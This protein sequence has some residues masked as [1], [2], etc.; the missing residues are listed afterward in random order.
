MF[1]IAAAGTVGQSLGSAPPEPSGRRQGAAS[2][3][4]PLPPAGPRDLPPMTPSTA[5]SRPWPPL[6]HGQVALGWRVV[7]A[8]GPG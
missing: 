5:R 1:Q 3:R 8:Q 4:R 7:A 2:Y 6:H